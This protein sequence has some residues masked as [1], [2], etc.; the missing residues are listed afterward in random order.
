M[1]A[2]SLRE[3]RLVIVTVLVLLYA[4][5]GFTAR[6]RVAAWKELMEEAETT[7][8]DLNMRVALIER[9]EH[10]KQRYADVRPLMPV[11]AADVKPETHWLRTHDDA[12]KIAGLNTSNA[13]PTGEI[14]AVGDVHEMAIECSDWR[15]SFE[16]LVRFLH[17]IHS[18]GAML[19]IRRLFIRPDPRAPGNL[20]G[21]FTL[22]CAYMKD[23]AAKSQNP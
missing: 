6:N 4:V 5:V 7:R 8:A 9:T 2:I 21:Q 15:G 17:E 20:S 11:F 16:Q 3:K 12:V 22:F 14:K 1:T 18:A 13:R 19:D 23:A 10:W